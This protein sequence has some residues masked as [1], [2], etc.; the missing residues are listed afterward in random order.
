MKHKSTAARGCEIVARDLEVCYGKFRALAAK[1]ITIRGNM[2]AV[3]GH[4]GAGKSTLIKALL[5]LLPFEGELQS[6]A[7]DTNGKCTLL[8]QRDMAFCPETG[9]VFADIS[10]ESYIKLWSRFKHRDGNYYKKEGSKYVDL[11]NLSPLFSKLGREL[12]KG[13]RRR[14]QTA[15]GFLGAPKLF[16]FDEPFDGLDVQ[17]TSELTS[18]LVEHQDRMSF[19]VS[20]HRMDVM[21]RIADTVVVLKDG[22]FMSSGS[23]E[24]VCKEL[25]DECY[26]LSNMSDQDS[27]LAMLSSRFPEL[28]VTRIGNQ[29]AVTGRGIDLNV[30]NSVIRE[31]DTN[32]IRIEKAHASLTDAMN[33]HLRSIK[34]L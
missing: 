20:S 8:P 30:L 22:E 27:M 15:I 11:L 10:V 3:I 5:G 17:K 24:S 33:Y 12:S 21:E 9:S 7:Q 16:F 1:Q 26:S 25:C 28:L 32:G 29:L 23:V 13:Q 14:V 2:I 34:H 18:I 4:N 6:F 19:V 31:Y